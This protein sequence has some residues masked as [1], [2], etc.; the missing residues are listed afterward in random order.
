MFNYTQSYKNL[1]L[2]YLIERKTDLA[3]IDEENIYYKI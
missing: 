2:I 3:I 1:S